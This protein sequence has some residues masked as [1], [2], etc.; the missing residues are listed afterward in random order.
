M[1]VVDHG[2]EFHFGLKPK[3]D[4]EIFSFVVFCSLF[5]LCAHIDFF[6]LESARQENEKNVEEIRIS[7]VSRGKIQ[8]RKRGELII[9]K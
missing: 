9:E 6:S 5:H 4:Q 3:M 8:G 2:D 1:R 7:F